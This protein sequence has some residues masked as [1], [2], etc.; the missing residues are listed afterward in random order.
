MGLSVSAA[1]AVLFTA[2]VIIFGVVFQAVDHAQQL[3]SQSMD[4]SQQLMIEKRQTNFIV[5]SVDEAN[6]TITLLNSGSIVL[7]PSALNVLVNGVLLDRE[8]I[9]M[10]VH[11]YEG[12]KVWA[13]HERLTIRFSC[14]ID[15]ARI[16]VI[17]GNGISA[18]YG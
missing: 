11:G 18:Y 16:K 2:F 17:A 10:E 9:K 12:S 4:K 7:S 3:Y 1:S 6:D 5:E 13:P 8:I 14:E 15:N